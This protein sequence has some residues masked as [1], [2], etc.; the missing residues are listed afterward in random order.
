VDLLSRL[1]IDPLRAA[2][3]ASA[4][5]GVL[6]LNLDGGSSVLERH[7]KQECGGYNVHYQT[8]G[9]HAGWMVAILVRHSS[10]LQR[11]QAC[12]IEVERRA[13]FSH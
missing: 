8:F 9:Y 4:G 7:G 1:G 10:L 11:R 6:E 12:S 13:G 2:L 5:D 3:L